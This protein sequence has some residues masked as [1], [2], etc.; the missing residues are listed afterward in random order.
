MNS[1]LFLNTFEFFRIFLGFGKYRFRKKIDT[2]VVKF[3]FQ[4]LEKLFTDMESC[5]KNIFE[6]RDVSL[7]LKI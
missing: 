7:F 2:I 3:L 1:L 4:S 5:D 6:S